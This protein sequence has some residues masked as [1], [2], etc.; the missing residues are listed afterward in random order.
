M[1][2]FQKSLI[3]KIGLVILFS[4]AL[5]AD[6]YDPYVGDTGWR[7][8]EKNNVMNH[9]MTLALSSDEWNYYMPGSETKTNVCICMTNEIM[10]QSTYREFLIMA[11]IK[12][13]EAG[14]R[15]GKYFKEAIQTQ[16]E[17]DVVKHYETMDKD[18][19]RKCATPEVANEGILEA[20]QEFKD[21][22]P[23]YFI[24]ANQVME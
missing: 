12:F 1:F 18:I 11:R 9:C 3:L 7:V 5:F 13:R 10:A 22:H 20:I 17:R 8:S 4:S 14:I 23:D 16:E 24:K 19:I 21:Q 6:V 15:Q 2:K